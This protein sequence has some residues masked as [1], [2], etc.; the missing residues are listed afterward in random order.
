MTTR[1][2]PGGRLL[3]FRFIENWPQPE[4]G[5]RLKSPAAAGSTDADNE[6]SGGNKAGGTVQ[7]RVAVPATFTRIARDF[8]LE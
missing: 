7:V 4:E 1:A 2:L 8:Q 3:L 6:S 5:A